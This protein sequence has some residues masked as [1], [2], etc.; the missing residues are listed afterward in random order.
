MSNEVQTKNPAAN[1]VNR[2]ADA[3]ERE[4][5]LVP[6]VDVIEDSAGITLLADLPGVPREKLHLQIDSDQLVIEGE[7]ALNLP[8]GATPSHAE[9]LVPRYRRSFQLSKELDGEQVSAE[10]KNG[11][12]KLRIP[13]ARHAQPRRIEVRAS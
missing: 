13:K 3:R 4:R 11:V 10:L 6:A 2:P 7:V 9:L 8:E 1:A 5:A 12:L